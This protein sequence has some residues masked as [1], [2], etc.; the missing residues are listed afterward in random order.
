M[1]QPDSALAEYLGLA[2]KYPE[3][4]YAAQSLYAAAWILENIKKDTTQAREIHQRILKDYP[5]SDYLKPAMEFLKVPLDSSGVEN[6]EA[7]YLEA[8]RML[9]EYENVDSAL[10]LY[11]SIIE[12][13]PQSVY[14]GKSAYAAAWLMEHYANPEDSTVALAY[15]KVIDEYPNSEYADAARVKLG[16]APKKETQ[17]PPIP[18]PQELPEEGPPDTSQVDTSLAAGPS[19]PMAPEPLKRGEFVYPESEIESGIEATVVL[20]IMI[21]F[22]GKVTDAVLISKTDNYWIDEAAKKAALETTF[23]PEKIDMTLLG[24]WFLYDVEVKPPQT[25]EDSHIDQPEW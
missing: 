12:R 7:V 9:E 2:D 21:D 23:D 1:N 13:F 11:N 6:P 16:L 17:P 4:E 10:I 14:A 3:S 24:G 25:D 5:G 18:K 22:E 19:I 15:Q 8:E 20:K